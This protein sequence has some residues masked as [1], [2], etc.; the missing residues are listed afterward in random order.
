MKTIHLS[1]ETNEIQRVVTL[2]NNRNKRH[3]Y[4]E[5][6]IEGHA[7]IDAAIAQGWHIKAFFY[8]SDIELSRWAQTHLAQEH[9]DVAYAIPESLMAKMS[10]KSDSS[11]LVAV[12]AAKERLLKDFQPNNVVVVLD[13][14]ITP[15]NVGMIIRSCV[16]FGACALI[17]SG[18]GVDEYDPKCIRASIGTFF[19]LPIYRISGVKEFSEQ[20]EKLRQAHDLS[21]IASG[22]KGS[23][24]IGDANFSAGI[25]FLVLGNE[26]SGVSKG[27]KEL[28][29]QFVKIPTTENFTSLNIAAAGSIFLYEIFKSRCALKHVT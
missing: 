2:K 3:R 16:A 26:T 1:K 14:P 7:A 11:E 25:L 20:I 21:I 9:A 28:A 15:G 12:V 8:Q 5:F 13:E 19:S 6:V 22:D 4:Q 18:H 10:E 17:I 24:L 29:N 27:Y 23:V